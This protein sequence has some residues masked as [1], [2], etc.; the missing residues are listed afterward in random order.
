[1]VKPQT[2]ALSV[3]ADTLDIPYTPDEDPWCGS[4]TIRYPQKKEFGPRRLPTAL[5]CQADTVKSLVCGGIL[6]SDM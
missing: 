3:Y 2:I 5:Y 4:M 6:Y 1:M